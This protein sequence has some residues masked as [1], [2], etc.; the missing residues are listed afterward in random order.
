MLSEGQEA[1]TTLC[2]SHGARS[3]VESAFDN[4]ELWPLWGVGALTWADYTGLHTPTLCCVP[5]PTGVFISAICDYLWREM[6]QLGGIE[7]HD[8]DSRIIGATH[9][10]RA[11][12]KDKELKTLVS[13]LGLQAEFDVSSRWATEI[14]CG[15]PHCGASEFPLFQA[16][17]KKLLETHAW[18]SKP[19]EGSER[20]SQI[21]I[22]GHVS[23]VIVYIW[24][25][26]LFIMILLYFCKCCICCRSSNT[27]LL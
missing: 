14:E 2:T 6:L 18:F 22:V 24:S 5:T 9:V 13:K 1:I 17:M 4:T 3:S 20:C 23:H 19:E 8:C 26:S 21:G 16:K 15:L 12:S 10:K 7:A 11:V 27:L 25:Y